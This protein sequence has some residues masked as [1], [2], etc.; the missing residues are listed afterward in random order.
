[1]TPEQCRAARGWLSWS[2][3]QLADAAGVGNST[4]KDFEAGRR[5]PIPATLKAMETA[6][7]SKGLGFAFA[8]DGSPSGITF[9]SENPDTKK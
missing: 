9:S 4:V 1:M 7:Q 8:E 2:Q 5:K 3:D 6:L